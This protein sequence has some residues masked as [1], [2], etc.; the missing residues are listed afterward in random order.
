MSVKLGN[1]LKFDTP[2]EKYQVGNKTVYVKRDDMM[3]DGISYPK[4]GKQQAILEI[5]N[6]V[7]FFDKKRPLAHLTTSDNLIDTWGLSILCAD[8]S[9]EL[10]C[11]CVKDTIPRELR[12]KLKE[13]GTKVTEFS[14]KKVSEA[15]RETIRK[16]SCQRLPHK[17]NC[18][19]FVRSISK[20]MRQVYDRAD[21]KTLV[22]PAEF[23]VVACG[24]AREFFHYQNIYELVPSSEKK[25]YVI[26][27]DLESS[28]LGTFTQYGVD[29]PNQVFIQPAGKNSKTEPPFSADIPGKSAWKFLTKNVD[30]LLGDILF[31]NMGGKNE[32]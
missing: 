10:R 17:Y 4:W 32:E 11:V 15:F 26:C 12:E 3:G 9:I 31:W 16:H 30:S 29:F 18:E 20:R 7:L 13:N 8:E 25:V 28:V 24:L 14:Q 6:N 1:G 5:F 19:P 2:V 21:F 27:G 22:V 23:G